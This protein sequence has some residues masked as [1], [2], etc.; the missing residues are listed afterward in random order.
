MSC[1]CSCLSI[2]GHVSFGE[3]PTCAQL[4]H[5][6]W[7]GRSSVGSSAGGQEEEEEESLSFCPPAAMMVESSGALREDI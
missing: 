5:D 7:T 2:F 3:R 1:V 4:H 6:H